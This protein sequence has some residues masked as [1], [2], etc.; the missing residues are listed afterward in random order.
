[1]TGHNNN[2]IINPNKTTCSLFTPDPAEYNSNLGLNINI[3]ALPVTL[4]TKV[5][6]RTLDPK[7][8]YNADIQNIATHSQKPLQVI[9]N[10]YRYNMG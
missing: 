2:L 9:K 8:T 1:M 5:L 10:T 6:G 7:L 3:K 4:H